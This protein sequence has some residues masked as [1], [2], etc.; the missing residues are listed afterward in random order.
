MKR[1]LWL[2]P[3]FITGV[4]LMLTMGCK[5]KADNTNPPT[6][7]VIGQSYGGG[8]IFY[9]DGTGQHGLIAA[10]SDQ[11]SGVNWGCYGILIGG[12]RT[13]IGTGQANTTAIINGC[14][15]A[16]IAARICD[17]LV[18][19]GYIDWFLPSEDELNQMYIQKTIIGG[20]ANGSYWSSS[21][22]N[23]NYAWSLYFNDGSQYNDSK[24]FIYYVRA[25]RAF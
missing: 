20:L 7:K 10:S 22:D 21:E 8:I 14:S 23:V 2:Y 24:N 25:V 6:P 13:A 12:T 3:V 17:D 1:K 18:L 4:F 16:G 19:N 5:K 9:I 11:S 15:T